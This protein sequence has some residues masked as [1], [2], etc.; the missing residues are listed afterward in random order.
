MDRRRAPKWLAAAAICILSLSV[1]HV[2]G[3]LPMIT[4]P[5]RIFVSQAAAPLYE[6]GVRLRAWVGADRTDESAGCPD[7]LLEELEALTVENAKLRTLVQENEEL[8]EALRFR[9]RAAGEL[10]MARVVSESPDSTFHGLILD[11]GSE[12]GIA[13]DQA[14][15]VGDGIIIG[16]IADVRPNSSAV[17]LLTDSRAALAVSLQNGGG[18]SGVLKGDRGLGMIVDLIPQ[19]E[20]IAP[21][22]VIVTSGIEP[23]IERGLV[24]GIV[25]EVFR[26]TRDPF[27][28]AAIVSLAAARFPVL[29]Q[30]VVGQD[31]SVTVSEI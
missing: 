28:S 25:D 13:L 12:H 22:D 10:V 21:G 27:Q 6:T 4:E 14:V 7:G 18:T 16:K 8:K 23:G 24:V 15:I 9:E 26:N 5:W 20:K 17:R 11:R 19:G 31:E 1:L 2:V 29:V 30:V 3:I